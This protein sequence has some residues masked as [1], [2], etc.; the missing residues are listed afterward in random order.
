MFE[1]KIAGGTCTQDKEVE[2]LEGGAADFWLTFLEPKTTN[3][4]WTIYHAGLAKETLMFR[5][6]EG[7]DCY[8]CTT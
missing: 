8:M 4:P 5:G 2:K 7:E 1:K 6:E 3:P